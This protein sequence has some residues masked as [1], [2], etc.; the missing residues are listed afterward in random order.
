M[1]QPESKP[2]DAKDAKPAAAPAKKGGAGL[3][4]AIVL[5]AIF[6]AGA[7]YAAARA[8][9]KGGAPAHAAPAPEHHHK[10]AKPPGPTVPLEPFLVTLADT[11]RKPHAMKVTLAVE[12]EHGTKEESLK[13]FTPRMR[14]ALLT[15]LR[16]IPYED[17]VDAERMEKIKKD[18]LEACQKAG[19]RDAERILVTDLVVQ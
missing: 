11:N 15:H 1:S 4:L 17:V 2:A 19:A 9:S 8:G 10:E 12:F 13:T 14:D 5:P 18:L 16:T 3:V 6:A 7:S